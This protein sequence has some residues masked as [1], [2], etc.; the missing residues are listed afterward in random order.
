MGLGTGV[1]TVKQIALNPASSARWTSI[2]VRDVASSGVVAAVTTGSQAYSIAIMPTDSDPAARLQDV[3]EEIQA[4][5]DADPDTVLADKLEDALAKVGIALIEFNK[6]PPDNLAA[7]GNIEG[8][9]GDLEATIGLDPAQD[10]AITDLADQLTGI[11]RQ[12]ASDAIEAATAGGGDPGKIDDALRELAE[13]DALR[14]EGAF[15]D[16]VNRYKDALAKAEGA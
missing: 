16:A 14:N 4:S 10:V 3:A 11:A 6:T 7:M 12:L 1:S 9:V 13:G 8:A 15:K 5:I 2:S